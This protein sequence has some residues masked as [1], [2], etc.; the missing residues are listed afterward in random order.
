M[1]VEIL[2]LIIIILVLVIL[3]YTYTK[4]EIKIERNV[5]D[6]SISKAW[7]DS[8]IERKMGEI[9]NY[10][11]SIQDDYLKLEKL[12]IKP[13]DRGGLGERSLE[14]ILSN[15]LRQ[16]M[17][18]IRKEVF[19]GKK[20]DAHIKTIDGIICIDS[21]FPLDNYQKIIESTDK[22]EKERYDKKLLK[23]TKNHLDKIIID[24]ISPENGTTNFAFAY[25]PSESVYEY[26]LT[27]HF[28]I[29]KDYSKQG[30]LVV[31]PLTLSQQIYLIQAG[32]KVNKMN[33]EAE[34]IQK[35]ISELSVLFNAL[36]ENWKV[37]SGHI[38]N[39]YNKSEELESD[40]K[41]LRDNFEKIN[42]ENN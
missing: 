18:G 35:E 37:F 25:I 26:L 7:T 3:Y 12:L 16:D 32:I 21:K 10:A 28:D 29:L 31:S 41:K 22:K 39:A 15:E 8:G 34:I 6:H 27:K 33:T 23:D 24:Y 2:L 17:F 36:D 4:K 11:K 5:I 9:S 30:L 40:H 20:P 42:K 13:G 14:M 1:I 38:R 19:S